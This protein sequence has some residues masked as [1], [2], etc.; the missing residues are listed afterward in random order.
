MPCLCLTGETP[1]RNLPGAARKNALDALAAQPE[2][3]ILKERLVQQLYSG[4]Y[5]GGRHLPA[6]L[7]SEPARRSAALAAI[8]LDDL[9]TVLSGGCL[10]AWP[11][12]TMEAEEGPLQVCFALEFYSA[13]LLSLSVQ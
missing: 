11:T 3:S 6:A 7:P 1:R 10:V 2:L 4:T 13:E 12:W 9:I 5:D 8:G